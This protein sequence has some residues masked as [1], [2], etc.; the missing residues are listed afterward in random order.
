M[1]LGK[2]G[3][4]IDLTLEQLFYIITTWVACGGIWF[5]CFMGKKKAKEKKVEMA[6]AG[7]HR[8][9]GPRALVKGRL[10]TI[11]DAASPIP[12]ISTGFPQLDQALV[13]GGL[14]KGKITELA[15]LPTS[16]KTTLALKFL[17][18][19]Q[20]G[21]GQVGYIDQARYFDPDYAH[22]CGLDLSRLIVGT[23]YNLQEALAMTETLAQRSN[24]AALLFDIQGIFWTDPDAVRHLT[25]LLNR[26]TAPLAHS[27]MVFLF[28]SDISTDDTPV[29]SA[30]AHYASVR[31]RVVRERWL[32]RYSDI[33]GYE[34][35]VEVLKNRLGPAGRLVTL[36]I[37]FNGTVS[38]ED[39]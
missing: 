35:R 26:V 34:A 4:N 27:G 8:R 9:F 6:V 2:L 36:K 7:V 15:G 17:A 20:D 31:L 19:A 37:H 30:L 11:V 29:L 24:L 5:E 12:C 38:G 21:K 16:G 23:P 13:I 18:Q 10:P 3:N 22:R 1:G 39:L 14:P 28:L 33:R 25:A 32:R